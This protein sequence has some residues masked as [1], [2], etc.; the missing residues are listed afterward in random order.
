MELYILDHSAHGFRCSMLMYVVVL[1]SFHKVLEHVGASKRNSKQLAQPVGSA[2]WLSSF[3]VRGGRSLCG[4]GG[5]I[6]SMHITRTNVR[7]LNRA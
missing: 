1:K 2:P 7:A 5:A 6:G 4:R 3:T